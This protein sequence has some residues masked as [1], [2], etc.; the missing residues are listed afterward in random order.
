MQLV[1]AVGNAEVAR[2]QFAEQVLWYGRVRCQT[3]EDIWIRERKLEE[4]AVLFDG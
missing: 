4:T 2:D 1:G 3:A